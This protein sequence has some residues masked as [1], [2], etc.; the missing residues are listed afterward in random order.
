MKIALI[1]VHDKGEL[2]NI[3]QVDELE[4]L[5]VGDVLDPTLYTIL[6]MAHTFR[7]I[8]IVPD[9]VTPPAHSLKPTRRIIYGSDQPGTTGQ[10]FN[11]G[12]TRG[13]GYLGAECG[14]YLEDASTLN[15]LDESLEKLMSGVEFLEKESFGK[16]ATSAFFQ[17]VYPVMDD[18]KT[19]TAALPTYKT[20]AEEKGAISV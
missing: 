4:A 17:A 8:E 7:L 5:L 12:L 20:E 16:V 19:L 15:T 13:I 18:T 14:V 11:V 10:F 9:G 6:G 2:E 1:V 3:T